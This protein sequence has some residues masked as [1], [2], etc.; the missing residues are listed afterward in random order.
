MTLTATVGEAPQQPVRRL[1]PM[2]W[3]CPAAPYLTH[4]QAGQEATG[5]GAETAPLRHRDGTKDRGLAPSRSCGQVSRLTNRYA[6]NAVSAFANCGRAVAHV[7]GRY[8]PL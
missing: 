3:C 1:R 6:W 7:R 2:A 5:G 8:G 4:R